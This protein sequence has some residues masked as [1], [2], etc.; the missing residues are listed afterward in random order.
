MGRRKFK[1]GRAHKR[2]ELKRQ[3]AKKNPVGRPPKQRRIGSTP[4][5]QSE[6]RQKNEDSHSEKDSLTIHELQQNLSLPSQWT[7][8]E[9]NGAGFFVTKVT[10]YPLPIV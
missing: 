10:P 7:V 9:D 4:T 3:A 8:Q 5:I 6:T 1:L 2:Y